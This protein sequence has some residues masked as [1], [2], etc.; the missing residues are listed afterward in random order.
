MENCGKRGGVVQ[1][2]HL[3]DEDLRVNGPDDLISA[4][5]DEALWSV[6]SAAAPMVF[7]R[8]KSGLIC[9]DDLDNIRLALRMMGTQLNVDEFARQILIDGIP[10]DD[11]SMD[12]LWVQIDDG[13]GFRPLKDTLRTVVSVEARNAAFHPVREFLN[14]LAWDGAPRL[15]RWLSVYGGATASPYVNAVGALPLIAAVR[16][17]RRPGTKFDEI[18]VLESAQAHRNPRHRGR[19][20]RWIRGFRTIC[21]WAPSPNTL[22]SALPE[23][24]S[25]RPPRC[26]ATAD[27]KRSS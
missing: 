6:L 12:C 20:A 26:T 1:H 27:V 22:S 8:R 17:A 15:D 18:L 23:S 14:S 9:A 10:A 19:S 3:P 13:F 25:L 11:V 21:R 4:L 7:K 16:R 5:G 2:A 24:E